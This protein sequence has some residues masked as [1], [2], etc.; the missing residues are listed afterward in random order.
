MAEIVE[1]TIGDLYPAEHWE[2]DNRHANTAPTISRIRSIDKTHMS[3][4]LFLPI[5]QR[6]IERI[7]N[8]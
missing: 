2:L 4:P 3:E 6:Q 5:S 7:E 1:P 8:L